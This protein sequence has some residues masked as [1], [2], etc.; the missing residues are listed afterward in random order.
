MKRTLFATLLLIGF[1]SIFAQAQDIELTDP[2]ELTPRE[3]EILGVT[4]EGN[5]NTRDQFIINA[6]SL[7]EGS[8]IVYPG[9]H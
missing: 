6:A 1:T 3:Y 8:S 2:T 5:E 7:N 4:I 9:M